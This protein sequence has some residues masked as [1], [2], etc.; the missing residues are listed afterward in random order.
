MRR[1]RGLR[2][3]SPRSFVSTPDVALVVAGVVLAT[4]LTSSCSEL[5]NKLAI[6]LLMR[7]NTEGLLSVSTTTMALA[8]FCSLLLGRFSINC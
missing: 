8:G 4:G 2:C 1:L 3:S 7:L 6:A 5:A